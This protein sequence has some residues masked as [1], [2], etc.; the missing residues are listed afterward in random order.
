MSSEREIL[1]R[2]IETDLGSPDTWTPPVEF[3][4]SLALCA[5]NSAYSLRAR[6]RSGQNVIARYRD[7]RPSA[8]TDSGPDLVQ[9]ID[10]AGGPAA[11][12][13]DVL[14]NNSKLPGTDQV[15]PEGIRCAL[16]GLAGLAHPVTTT[17]DL[18][19]AG[20]SGDAKS[21][22]LSVRGL[23]PLS[24]SYLLMNAGVESVTKPDV[25]IRDYLAHALKEDAPPEVARARTLLQEAADDL[26]VTPRQLDR[27]IW[28]H[29]R[30]K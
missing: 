1:R 20:D 3:R 14:D 9:C 11:F 17:Q 5:L 4:G 18:R 8:D 10:D 6:S 13:R 24:W 25:H 12:A 26:G 27:A 30:A 29:E 22:W 16:M 21:A 23:G 7:H 28:V 15:R 2:M 19:A